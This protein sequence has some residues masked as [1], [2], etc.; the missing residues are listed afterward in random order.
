MSSEER[1]NKAARPFGLAAALI[2]VF[3]MLLT[4]AA[5]LSRQLFN[6]PLLGLVEISEL[7]LVACIFIA[8][9]GAFLRDENVVVDVVD[10]MVPRRVTHVL[11]ML[12]LVLTLA[13]LG[14][15]A[16]TMIE[17]AWVKFN[18]G[19]TT[20]V[21]EIDLLYFWIPILLGFYL[22]SAATLW[23][24]LHRLSRGGASGPPSSGPE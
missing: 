19:Q 15:S 16:V 24:L 1:F 5:V 7:A 17:P 4:T 8:M 22:A 6:V 23:L 9:P 14:G 11:R 18:R 13:F 12:G 10:H 21:L 2:L 3:M 20:M